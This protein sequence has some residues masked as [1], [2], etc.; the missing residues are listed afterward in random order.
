LLA[1]RT[2]L[3]KELS[4]ATARRSFVPVH[5]RGQVQ[6]LFKVAR[7]RVVRGDTQVVV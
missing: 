3:T 1:D 7:E 6:G 5:D 4:R 2:G